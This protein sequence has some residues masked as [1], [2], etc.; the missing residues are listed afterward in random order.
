M[1]LRIGL[2]LTSAS[3]GSEYVIGA[4]T[5]WVG[6]GVS[7]FWVHAVAKAAEIRS[8]EILVKRIGLPLGVM[9]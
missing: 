6:S 8:D 2:N 7:G 1:S 4:G 9:R 5:V 3:V